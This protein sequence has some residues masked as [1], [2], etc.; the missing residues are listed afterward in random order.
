MRHG[1]DWKLYWIGFVCSTFDVLGS[2]MCNQ[3]IKTGSPVG[4][5][6]A[7]ADSQI[8]ITTVVAAAR[9]GVVPHWMQLVG[10]CFGLLGAVV[11]S[12]YKYV[13]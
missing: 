12:L 7:L 8:V 3:A 11:L 10:L 9:S 2:F 13:F 5:I 4:A 6:F 1:I